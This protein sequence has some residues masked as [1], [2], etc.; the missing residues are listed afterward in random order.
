VLARTRV[1]L[2]FA[3]AFVWAI[4]VTVGASSV[5]GQLQ[6]GTIRGTVVGPDG[7][8]VHGAVV[9]LLDALASP[10]RSVAAPDGHFALRNIAPGTYFIHASAPPLS[11]ALQRV[12]VAG[13]LA[14][15]IE[16]P[17]AAG[18]TAQVLVRNTDIEQPVTTK[19][20]TLGGEAIRRAPT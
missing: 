3:F 15:D 10:L 13:A 12:V 17:V 8:L 19:G 14:V 18:L 11:G 7:E 6:E 1:S 2:V 9:T 4:A 16:L 20:I 5:C